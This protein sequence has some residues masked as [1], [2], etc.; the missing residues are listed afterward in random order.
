MNSCFPLLCSSPSVS[1]KQSHFDFIMCIYDSG[2]PTKSQTCG[3]FFIFLNKGETYII[4]LFKLL[5]NCIYT[6]G[7]VFKTNYSH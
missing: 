7:S 3:N 4:T 6:W 5:L 1:N 2:V